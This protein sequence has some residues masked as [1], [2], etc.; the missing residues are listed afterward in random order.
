MTK[1]DDFRKRAQH[2]GK[3]LRHRVQTTT[4]LGRKQKA[5]TDMAANEDWLD[6]MILPKL[7]SPVKYKS[8]KSVP[9][10]VPLVSTGTRR[11]RRS[12]SSSHPADT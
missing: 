5:L 2:I 4:P 10:M 1:A 12:A 9:R 3:R 8:S 7:K 11:E 6:G